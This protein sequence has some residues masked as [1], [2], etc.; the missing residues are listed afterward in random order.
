MKKIV[1]CLLIF[2]LCLQV[3]G[4]TNN[5]DVDNINVNNNDPN[6]V[7]WRVGTIEELDYI[8]EGMI[9][10][11][12]DPLN[13]LLKE[14]GVSYQVEI[15]PLKNNGN[16][17][18]IK[19]LKELQ[20]NG[21]QTDMVTFFP[22][23]E[24]DNITSRNNIYKNA[25]TSKLLLNL[26]SWKKKHEKILEEVLTPYDF[27]L[28]EI[29]HKLY[30]LASHVPMTTANAYNKELLDK[31]GVDINEIKSNIYD[32]EEI[33]MRVKE[34]SGESPIKFMFLSS[35]QL[36]LYNAN[37]VKNLAFKKGEGFIAISKSQELK[38]LL[39]HAISFKKQGLTDQ[40]YLGQGNFTFV[41]PADQVISK[42]EMFNVNVN[43]GGKTNEV[44]IIPDYTEKN[45]HLYRGDYKTGIASWSKNIDNAEDFLL[46]LYSDKDIANLIQYGI[47]G[48]DYILDDNNHITVTTKNIGLKSYGAS[49][50]NAK[51]TYSSI[52]E[53]D[54]KVAYSNWFYTKYGDEFPA[55]F[56][57]EVNEM[58]KE[59]NNTNNIMTGDF[60]NDNQKSEWMNKIARYEIDDLDKFLKDL[61]KELDKV[62][63]KKIVNEANRQYQEWLKGA[64]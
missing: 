13:E 39:Q 5:K 63:M 42:R 55:G 59:I 62:G 1:L 64:K 11:W 51:I 53:E 57:L 36:G 4:C 40:D 52:Y 20:K 54:D 9:K 25:A 58:I 41:T 3:T 43:S 10:V 15:I 32:N 23:N 27:K 21:E 35:F 47:E 17:S 28:S 8:T 34:Q 19:N 14:K 24:G 45:M 44:V 46:K 50:T 30:G 31:Y 18:Q 60:V 22:E 2:V 33:L 48:E 26:D 37:P 56:R 49:V 29:N 6:T 38:Q 12:Q 61:N 16:N 7:V